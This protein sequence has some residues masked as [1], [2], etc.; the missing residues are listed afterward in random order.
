MKGAHIKSNQV[1]GCVYIHREECGR[2]E[3]MEEADPFLGCFF[4]EA[5]HLT[6]RDVSQ[7]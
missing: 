5:Q 7:F 3:L 6:R 1:D 4:S 2:S